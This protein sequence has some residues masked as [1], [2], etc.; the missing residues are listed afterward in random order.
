MKPALKAEAE[1]D[2]RVLLQSKEWQRRFLSITMES[3]D[4][5]WH[6]ICINYHGDQDE[7]DHLINEYLDQEN[8]ITVSTP[9]FVFR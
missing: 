4:S 1:Q 3:S 2:L 7:L 9:M 8:Q 6:W 5:E